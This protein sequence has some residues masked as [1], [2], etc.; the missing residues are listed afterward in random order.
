MSVAARSDVDLK[1]QRAIATTRNADR[2]RR[3]EAPPARIEVRLADG[4]YRKVMGPL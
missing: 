1:G 3:A 2:A 4:Y